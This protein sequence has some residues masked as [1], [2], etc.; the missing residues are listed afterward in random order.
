MVVI[1]PLVSHPTPD[2]LV[3]A[4]DIGILPLHFHPVVEL[5]PVAILANAHK[6]ISCDGIIDTCT[7]NELD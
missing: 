2:Q 1:V 4:G 3:H 6:A 7:I 5:A